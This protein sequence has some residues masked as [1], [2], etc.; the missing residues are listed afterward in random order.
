MNAVYVM[1]E[2]RSCASCSKNIDL[3]MTSTFATLRLSNRTFW[4]NYEYA[5]FMKLNQIRKRNL[6]HSISIGNYNIITSPDMR[7]FSY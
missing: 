2:A 6:K 7:N 4:T 5:I 1:E 3:V